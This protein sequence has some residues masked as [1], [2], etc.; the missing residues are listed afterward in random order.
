MFWFIKPLIQLENSL[1]LF[2]QKHFRLYI[3]IQA[4]HNVKLTGITLNV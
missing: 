3:G 4:T 2:P 1:R